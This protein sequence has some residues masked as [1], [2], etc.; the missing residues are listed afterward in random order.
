LGRILAVDFR[1]KRTGIAVKDELQII[2]SSL[3]TINIM[4][5]ISRKKCLLRIHIKRIS[6]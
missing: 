5:L 4:E 1:K 6:M 3:A 2:A